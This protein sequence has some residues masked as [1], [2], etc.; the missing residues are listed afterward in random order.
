M[1]LLSLK[2]TGSPLGLLRTLIREISPC[3]HPHQPGVGLWGGQC[4]HKSLA[5]AENLGVGG[6]MRRQLDLVFKVI[7]GGLS[8]L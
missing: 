2:D 4:S 5:M 8:T 3:S 7:L 6:A 1:A